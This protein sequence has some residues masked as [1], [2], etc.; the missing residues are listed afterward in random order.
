VLPE[1]KRHIVG[2]HLL[3]P[4][5]VLTARRPLCLANLREN[6][7]EQDEGLALVRVPA[8]TSYSSTLVS[9]HV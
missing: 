5:K 3:K 2:T 9:L 1:K 7:C 4:T 6:H 8:S